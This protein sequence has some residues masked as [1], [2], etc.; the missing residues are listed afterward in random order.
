M[1]F[2]TEFI[3]EINARLDRPMSKSLESFIC[4]R[5]QAIPA[6]REVVTR[7]I[8]EPVKGKR[9]PLI[10]EVISI[11]TAEMG[12]PAHTIYLKHR[13]TEIKTARHIVYYLLHRYTKMSMREMGEHFDNQHHTT[14]LHGIRNVKNWLETGDRICNTIFNCDDKLRKIINNG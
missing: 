8:P 2:E 12:I 6:K 5:L 10:Q 11:V 3:R 14:V 1:T 4:S 9:Q 7:Y 13:K